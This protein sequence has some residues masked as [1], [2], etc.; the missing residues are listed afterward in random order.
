[1]KI[2]VVTSKLPWP[3]TG[4]DEQDRFEGLKLL[5]EAGCE[6]SVIAKAASHQKPEDARILSQVIDANVE[7]VPYGFGGFSMK[8]IFDWK[9]MDGAAYEY[10]DPEL[11]RLAEATIKAFNPNAVW[12]DGSFIWPVIPL[13]RA[14]NLPVIVR[15]LQIESSHVFADEG[16][17]IPNAA[18]AFFKEL[19]E[20]YMARHADTVVAINRNEEELYRRMG[21]KRAVTVP[22]R[23]LPSILE[24]GG[25]EYRNA[26]PL[27]ILFTASTFSV[28]HNREGAEKVFRDIAPALEKS[29]PGEF[30]VHVT[31]AKLPEAAV[32]ELPRNVRYE[33]YI[34][35][36][37]A[38]MKTI[39]IAI[40]QSLGTV[41]MHGKLFAPVAEG[42]PTVTQGHALAG[43][44]FTD[45]EHLLIGETPHEVVDC[46]LRLRDISL[47]EK[48]GTGGRK[49]SE[50]L[51]SRTA[52]LATLRSVLT[53]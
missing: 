16:I 15:S 38:F 9:Y 24:K 6:V 43:F 7:T 51:F 28:T 22:L 45:G 27:H 49:L 44:P 20:R 33:G 34:A 26:R 8:R 25:I 35:D 39:D 23:Q 52:L 48:I 13:A 30:I 10:A 31:G 46:L 21:A 5:K 3:A 4:A 18:R 40:T 1:M 41:G 37:D 14:H 12:L 53:A 19:G 42:I 2:L 50:E 11:L 47:R 36:F 17:S 32:R 29:A